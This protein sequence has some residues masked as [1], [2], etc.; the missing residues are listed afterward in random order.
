MA[1][2]VFVVMMYSFLL[3][4]DV[5]SSPDVSSDDSDHDAVFLFLLCCFLSRMSALVSS[6]KS[7]CLD[8]VFLMSLLLV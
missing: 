8:S 2:N 6:V 1:G 3:F 5:C 4:C 7:C